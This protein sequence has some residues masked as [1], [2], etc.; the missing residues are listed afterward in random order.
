MGSSLVAAESVNSGSNL[1][2]IPDVL[3]PSQFFESVGTRTWSSEQRLMLAVLADA[4]NVL[5]G[6]RVSIYGGKHN[7]F[8][9]AL[10]WVFGER[11]VTSLLSFDHVCDALV[12][13][14]G[15]LRKRLWE[16]VSGH[17]GN[18]RKLKLKEGGRMQCVAV[19]RVRRR[20]TSRAR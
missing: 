6:H 11:R 14:T 16:A 4:I 5:Q 8:N 13:D 18:F 3:L 1:N 2:R 20:G 7:P 12:L 9:E 15:N 17:G 19:N 10:S